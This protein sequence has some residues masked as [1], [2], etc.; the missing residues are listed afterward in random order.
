MLLLSSSFSCCGLL[1]F[2]EAALYE[3]GAMMLL[4]SISRFARTTRGIFRLLFEQ[5]LSRLEP[6]SLTE[7]ED[8]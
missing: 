7:Y 6:Q 5:L 4:T 1:H 2:S 8:L 3:I